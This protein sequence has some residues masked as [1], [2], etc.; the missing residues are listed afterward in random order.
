MSHLAI[1]DEEK[2]IVGSIQQT[3]KLFDVHARTHRNS[4]AMPQPRQPELLSCVDTPSISIAEATYRCTRDLERIV[5]SDSKA[6]LDKEVASYLLDSQQ[7][8]VLWAEN[9][10]ALHR[11]D[12][13]KSAD[14][15]LKEA[16]A[17]ARH[18]LSL[19]AELHEAAKDAADIVCGIRPDQSELNDADDPDSDDDLNFEGADRTE[20]Q[21]LASCI[22]GLVTSLLKVTIYA[23]KYTQ[24]DRFLN[25]AVT[26]NDPLLPEPDILH[27]QDKFPKTRS[28]DRRWLREKLGKAITL[29]RQVLRY[30]R[31]HGRRV[32]H[33]ARPPTVSARA[34]HP[35]ASDVTLM[36]QSKTQSQA[37]SSHPT[38]RST[39]IS[40]IVQPAQQGLQDP[41][42]LTSQEQNDGITLVSRREKEGMHPEDIRIVP[43]SSVN[44]GRSHFKCPYCY[45][46]VEINSQRRWE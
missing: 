27:V 20:I 39:E 10:G 13:R 37:H 36:P 7:R 44:E 41:E 5:A 29:R 45:T 14:H 25:A 43:L 12:S 17:L 28:D 33:K 11:L 46:L 9:F 40:A 19:L 31:E 32:A 2:R 26:N 15:R 1:F 16:P 18:I 6:A 42:F 35:F 22:V 8:F 30:S 3:P 24:K 21:V 38:L 34:V 23:R 4:V